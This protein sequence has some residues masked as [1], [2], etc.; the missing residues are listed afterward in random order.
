MALLIKSSD[1]SDGAAGTRTSGAPTLATGASSDQKPSLAARAAISAPNPAVTFAS[2][3]TTQLIGPP[4]RR[5]NGVEV[6]RID[7][8]QIDQID[9][10]AT[11]GELAD[12]LEAVVHRAAPADDGHIATLAQPPG[13][14]EMLDLGVQ[15]HAARLRIQRPGLEHDHRIVACDPRPE[16][17]VAS[18][19]Q[20]GIAHPDARDVRE[21]RLDALRVLRARARA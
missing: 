6:E 1:C 7:P 20:A 5:E 8:P 18:S 15:A 19:G 17:L 11:L 14:A 13:A 10:D 4:D 16:H 3:T 2:W 21:D 9:L 12:S